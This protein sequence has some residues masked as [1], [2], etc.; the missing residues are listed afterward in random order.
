MEQKRKDRGEERWGGGKMERAMVMNVMIYDGRALADSTEIFNM[1][2]LFISFIYCT[3]IKMKV[4]STT[5]NNTLHSI[6]QNAHP[7]YRG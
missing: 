7:V 5:F 3:K 2:S 1:S 6:F 4:C